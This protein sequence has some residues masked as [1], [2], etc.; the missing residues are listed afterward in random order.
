MWIARHPSATPSSQL[1]RGA[2]PQS[3]PLT[4]S[5][6]PP[7]AVSRRAL[8]RSARRKRWPQCHPPTRTRALQ[9]VR[10]W[11]RECYALITARSEADWNAAAK[12]SPGAWEELCFWA[13]H[14]MRWDAIGR[15]VFPETR[16]VQVK[17]RGDA[18]PES[19]GAR[20][21]DVAY[22]QTSK[23]YVWST[24]VGSHSY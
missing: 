13:A 12:V 22:D 3:P 21:L 7:L 9:P 11:S 2:A 8:R 1:S 4:P 15:R 5:A 20:V 16:P 14:L 6:A 17:L 18:E 23:S 10:L 19:W 24:S